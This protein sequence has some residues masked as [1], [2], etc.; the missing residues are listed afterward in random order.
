MNT[1]S[2]DW[3]QCDDAESVPDRLSG[4]WVVKGTRVPVQ[5]VIDNAEDGYTAEQIAKEIFDNLPL[6]RVRGILRFAKLGS[7]A[8]G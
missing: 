2:I 7:P 3:S 6:D 1:Q 4:A 8:S 5:A